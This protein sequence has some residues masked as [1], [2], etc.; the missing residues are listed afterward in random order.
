MKIRFAK[1]I[2]RGENPVVVYLHKYAL[3]SGILCFTATVGDDGMVAL[4]E[5]GQY[6][7]YYGKNSYSL[8]WADARKAVIK[9]RDKKRIYLQT[10]LDKLSDM[11][12]LKEEPKDA[13]I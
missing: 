3:T 9:K 7:A 5:K 6:M 10:Q 13:S 8:T 1:N 2:I 12:I 4:K 11:I